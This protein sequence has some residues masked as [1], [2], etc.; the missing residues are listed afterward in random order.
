MD[1]R[2]HQQATKTIEKFKTLA[3]YAKEGGDKVGVAS[4]VSLDHATP[5]ATYAK[6][7]SITSAVAPMSSLSPARMAS[8]N[9]KAAFDAL[10][11]G[12]GKVFGARNYGQ[13]RGPERRQ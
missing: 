2:G 8:P 10:K 9:S 13:S 7:A 12:V 1:V 3:E 4:S 5:A 6:L 11:P